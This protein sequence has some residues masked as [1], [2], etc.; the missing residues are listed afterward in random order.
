MRDSEKKLRKKA[1]RKLLNLTVY[2]IFT[3]YSYIFGKFNINFSIISKTKILEFLFIK[4]IE[5]IYNNTY[6][7]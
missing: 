6:N 7:F 4:V 5:I 2:F 3:K 1:K